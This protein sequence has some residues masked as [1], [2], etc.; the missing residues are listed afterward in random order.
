MLQVYRLQFTPISPFETS[1][2]APISQRQ[3]PG[4]LSRSPPIKSAEATRPP[5]IRR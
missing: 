1:F 5:A 2:W 4:E 3:R